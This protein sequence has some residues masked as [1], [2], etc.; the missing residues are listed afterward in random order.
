MTKTVKKVIVDLNE[1]YT[2]IDYKDA[3][4]HIR[5]LANL[6]W[7]GSITV[8]HFRER[9]NDII[10]VISRKELKVNSK[11]RKESK[12]HFLNYKTEWAE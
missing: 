1:M 11:Q 5:E 2:T 4:N 6:E 3:F 12:W 10:S 9:V 7:N 8:S